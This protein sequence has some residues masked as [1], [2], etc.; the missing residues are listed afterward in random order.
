MIQTTTLAR[1]PYL[2]RQPGPAVAAANVRRPTEPP[3]PP[4]RAAQTVTP[5]R[6][7]DFQGLAQILA[8]S[9]GGPLLGGTGALLGMLVG[10]P[11]VALT[12]AL[13]GASL[14]GLI[15]GSFDVVVGTGDILAGREGGKGQLLLGLGLLAGGPGLAWAGATLGSLAGGVAAATAGAMLAPLLLAGGFFLWMGH[16]IRSIPKDS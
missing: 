15:V 12:L 8:V 5:R 9:L 16:K 11:A 6:L 4:P 2:V 10:G 7:Q 1:R 13:A 14:P 3:P